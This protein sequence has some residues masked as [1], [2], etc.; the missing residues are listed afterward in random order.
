MCRNNL[1]GRGTVIVN[2]LQETVQRNI[3]QEEKLMQK[4]NDIDRLAIIS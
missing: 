2:L 3:S 4:E 1:K